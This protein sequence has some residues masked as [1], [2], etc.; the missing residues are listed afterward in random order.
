MFCIGRNSSKRMY[1][2]LNDIVLKSSKMQLTRIN[3][4]KTYSIILVYKYLQGFAFNV[5]LNNEVDAAVTFPKI[6]RTSNQ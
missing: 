5:T 6:L 4:M 1:V 2:Y 3:T